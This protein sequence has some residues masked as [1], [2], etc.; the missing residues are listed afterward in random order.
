[1][2]DRKEKKLFLYKKV[3]SIMM[4]GCG[5]TK[6]IVFLYQNILERELKA[7][8]NSNDLTLLITH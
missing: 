4:S 7:K 3:S 6:V 2:K 1:M 8:T 5:G